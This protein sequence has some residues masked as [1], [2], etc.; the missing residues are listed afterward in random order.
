LDPI[1]K[2][3]AGEVDTG[4]TWMDARGNP[5]DKLPPEYVTFCNWVICLG[6]L[7]QVS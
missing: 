3:M 6:I 7:I 5:T 1:R 4:G 2:A